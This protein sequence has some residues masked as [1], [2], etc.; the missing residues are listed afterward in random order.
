MVP[1]THLI[2]NKTYTVSNWQ[3]VSDSNCYQQ[4]AA[5][6]KALQYNIFYLALFKSKWNDINYLSYCERNYSNDQNILTFL[7]FQTAVL[8]MIGE[9]KDFEWFK[10]KTVL[11]EIK[12]RSPMAENIKPY[13]T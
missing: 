3:T 5:F 6:Q 1:Y 2:Y 7:S 10:M 8:H 13:L 11:I 4:A 9:T 12:Q